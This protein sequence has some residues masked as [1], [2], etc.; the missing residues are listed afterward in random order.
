MFV[1]RFY[2]GS[3][4]IGHQRRNCSMIS[5]ESVQASRR[6]GLTIAQCRSQSANIEHNWQAKMVMSAGIIILWRN[7]IRETICSHKPG[8]ASCSWNGV[9][10]KRIETIEMHLCWLRLQHFHYIQRLASKKLADRRVV[11][12][13]YPGKVIPAANTLIVCPGSRP[14][15][16]TPSSHA[17]SELRTRSGMLMLQNCLHLPRW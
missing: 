9:A 3:L 11:I 8:G 16:R 6:R 12:D 5:F 13:K 7:N 4:G 1:T 14:D 10:K 2:A 15:S 17:D